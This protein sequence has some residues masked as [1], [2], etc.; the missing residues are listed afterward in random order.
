MKYMMP[1]Y[2][3]SKVTPLTSNTMSTRYGN[4]AVKYTT[5]KNKYENSQAQTITRWG[6]F[7]L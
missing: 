2:D 3:P 1:W 5:Y 4:V 6:S 7:S